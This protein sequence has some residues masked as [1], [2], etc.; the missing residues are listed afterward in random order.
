M[1]YNSIMKQNYEE[2]RMREYQVQIRRCI[3]DVSQMSIDDENVSNP[4]AG[5]E[6]E[7]W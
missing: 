5:T 2:P 6:E 3:C 1:N 7:N 4:F